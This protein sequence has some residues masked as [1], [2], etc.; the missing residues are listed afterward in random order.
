VRIAVLVI[1]FVLATP[2]R[3]ITYF[4]NCRALLALA[5]EHLPAQLN[6]IEG[7]IS[8][9]A[10]P[11]GQVRQLGNRN[12][13]VFPLETV[14]Q[15]HI[16]ESQLHQLIDLI[17]A[18]ALA[19]AEGVR[20]Q[21]TIDDYIGAREVLKQYATFWTVAYTEPQWKEFLPG[22][23]SLEQTRNHQQLEKIA[24]QE[25]QAAGDFIRAYD[26]P[27]SA[28]IP[29]PSFSIPGPRGPIA[30]PW[31][32]RAIAP[33]NGGLNL[34]FQY[35]GEAAR[36]V[37]FSENFYRKV[38]DVL[39]SN[40]VEVPTKSIVAHSIRDGETLHFRQVIEALQNINIETY[41]RIDTVKFTKAVATS[42]NFRMFLELSRMAGVGK[43]L[44]AREVEK[45]FL[46]KHPE[47]AGTLLRDGNTYPVAAN[48]EVFEQLF[49]DMND[50]Y[51][52]NLSHGDADRV[53]FL[54]WNEFRH[55]AGQLYSDFDES[56][57]KRAT[58]T[59]QNAIDKRETHGFESLFHI[60]DSEVALDDSHAFFDQRV[61]TDRLE[62]RH[63]FDYTIF[64]NR[65][66]V[67][68]LKIRSLW[69]H[70]ETTSDGLE[71]ADLR[72]T[73]YRVLAG[74]LT[75]LLTAQP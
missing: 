13:R 66:R 4:Y 63:Q 73:H 39:D 31:A 38:G 65:M 9:S 58:R 40:P 26:L 48:L 33:P 22:E 24:R 45:G 7:L 75:E 71:N 43:T 12:H 47:L 11:K 1:A 29:I 49:Y 2:A 56:K 28:G 51:Y 16:F 72:E 42:I 15:G 46:E 10:L 70:L 21:R 61:G 37:T 60:A 19:N 53:R 36:N 3:A 30:V 69:L 62:M 14:P 32:V 64:N 25:L 74:R 17:F 35:L 67:N 55:L 52:G 34:S 23:H 44:S 18:E 68:D 59:V 5:T 20:D 41:G 54:G 6:D 50:Y 8:A 27:F 57:W